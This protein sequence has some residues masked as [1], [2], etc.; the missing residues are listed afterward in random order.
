MLNHSDRRVDPL[1]HRGICLSGESGNNIRF[2]ESTIL[3]VILGF[4]LIANY[5]PASLRPFFWA[6]IEMCE[7]KEEPFNTITN[8]ESLADSFKKADVAEKSMGRAMRGRTAERFHASLN[9]D[10]SW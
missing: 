2:D 5:I 7:V 9:V 1:P 8:Y 3:H 6:V 10:L 4:L